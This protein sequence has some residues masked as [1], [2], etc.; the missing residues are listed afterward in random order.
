MVRAL[1]ED[2]DRNE[3]IDGERWIMMKEGV[4]VTVG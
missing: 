2:R 4:S 1:P 3:V